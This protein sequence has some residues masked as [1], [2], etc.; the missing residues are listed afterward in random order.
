M[1]EPYLGWQFWRGTA[2]AHDLRKVV[3]RAVRDAQLAG[4]L[5]SNTDAAMAA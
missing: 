2:N 3:E 5:G 4:L 1:A